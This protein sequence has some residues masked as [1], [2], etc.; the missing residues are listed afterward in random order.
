MIGAIY[1]RT[2][3]EQNTSDEEKSVA[4]QIAH[5]RALAAVLVRDRARE[6]DLVHRWLDAWAGFG[7]VVAGMTHQGWDV[8]LT[9]YSGRDW[10]ANFFPVGIAH[11][12]VGGSA[13]EPT[14]WRA[15]AA[16]GVGGSSSAAVKGIS[17]TVAEELLHQ[18]IETLVADHARWQT[19]LADDVV[20]ELPFAPALGHP[21][22][23]SGRAEVV[24][25]AAWFVG[26]VED[27]RF[28]D[29][30]VQA[31]ATRRRPSRRSRARAGSRQPGGPTVRSTSCSC[32]QLAARCVPAR[33]LRSD[34]GGEGDGRAHPRPRLVT[35][36]LRCRG[37][38]GRS[39]RS[40]RRRSPQTSTH[41]G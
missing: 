36:G 38:R 20:W 7:L 23:V 35:C 33:V 11:S 34:P 21:A 41:Y 25:F 17:M 4:R 28:F 5:A 2:S 18:H 9:A 27:F 39:S 13:W 12:I 1:A 16:G 29:V 3:T 40:L 19:M 31:F 30:R 22:R 37:R 26:A 24:Q 32:V 15:G 8:Q 6:L 14:R 10:R